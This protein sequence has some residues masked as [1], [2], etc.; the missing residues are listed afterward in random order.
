MN[1][2]RWPQVR[3]GD[4]LTKK[5]DW[6]DIDPDADYRQVTVKMWGAGVTLR[7]IVKGSGIAASSQIKVQAR[8]F[9]VSKID[10]RH[11]AFGIVPDTLD[12]AIVSQDF[13]VFEAQEKRLLPEFLGWLSK[14]DWFVDLCR[15]SSEGSTNRVRLREDRFLNHTVPLPPV[16]DQRRILQNLD[17]VAA[18]IEARARKGAAMEAELA[19]AL[20]SGFQKITAGA[21]RVRMGVVAPLIR[22]PV[23]IEPDGI[24]HEL[25]VRSFGRGLFDKPPLTG[26]DLT[27]QKLFQI[28]K[29]DLVFSNIK[30]WEGAFAVA[31]PQDDGKV[32][33]HRYLTCV[34]IPDRATPNFLW[35]YLQT[36][37]GL[38]EIQAASPGSADRNRTLN[39]KGLEEIEIPVPAIDAQRWFDELQLKAAVTRAQN[40][41]VVAELGH[42]IPAMLNK[43]F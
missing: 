17:A 22:R 29:G 34:A 20:T 1:I 28:R 36:K 3:L 26:A 27:W 37:E 16:P 41:E 9:I 4:V 21:T 2:A 10:A 30:A 43:V 13:P 31:K 5:T 38:E 11:G 33:S 42:L 6:I 32:G 24:Y 7:R 23:E 15:V 40:A 12:G 39:Q 14:T 8:Q 25:G 35:Y 19:A 18:G